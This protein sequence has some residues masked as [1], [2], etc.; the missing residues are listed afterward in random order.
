[1]RDPRHRRRSPR[2]KP[3]IKLPSFKQPNPSFA[4]PF[5][6]FSVEYPDLASK[7]GKLHADGIAA[8]NKGNLAKGKRLFNEILT[9][10]PSGNPFWLYAHNNLGACYFA[11][12][13]YERARD[14][15]LAATEHVPMYTFSLAMLTRVYLAMGDIEAAA[16]ALKRAEATCVPDNPFWVVHDDALNVMIEAYVEFGDFHSALRLVDYEEP[17]SAEALDC[18]VL[19]VAAFNL[20]RYKEANM[21][22]QLEAQ[23]DGQERMM[24][25][26]A[27]VALLLEHKQLPP[28]QIKLHEIKQEETSVEEP[29][30]YS[31]LLK[32][33]IIDTVWSDNPTAQTS[34]LTSMDKSD[35]PWVES[36][37]RAL[38]VQADLPITVKNA[39]WSALH[40]MGLVRQGEQVMMDLEGK[41][42]PYQVE[43]LEL[44]PAKRP[45]A[46]KAFLKGCQYNAKGDPKAAEAEFRKALRLYPMFPEAYLNLANA[47]RS[48]QPLDQQRFD[49]AQSLLETA[50]ALTPDYSLAW[51]NLAGLLV[52]YDK[53]HEAKTA[54]DK[55]DVNELN[56]SLVPNYWYMQGHIGVLM[57]DLESAAKAFRTGLDNA[58][59]PKVRALLQEGLD[60]INAFERAFA[61]ALDIKIDID[62]RKRMLRKS[63]RPGLPLL[64][65]YMLQT[66]EDLQN[67]A[68]A[69]GYVLPYRYTK[70]SMAEKLVTEMLEEGMTYFAELLDPKEKE[71]LYWLYKQGGSVS[72]NAFTQTYGPLSNEDELMYV[73]QL[74]PARSLVDLGWVMIGTYTSDGARQTIATLPAEVFEWIQEGGL[75]SY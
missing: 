70:A 63:I 20:Q 71:A 48:Q 10:G 28:F 23:K 19:G 27:R 24:K 52:E 35:D 44:D 45:A 73:Q 31:G 11:E 42:Q 57:G 26:L 36:F 2:R 65:A 54:L 64:E 60:N 17:V 8:M 53:V 13:Q 12:K 14:Y 38:L 30:S 1:M 41:A 34:I 4:D 39:A 59:A 22:W 43:R 25:V 67:I 58:V 33:V 18:F 37:L 66:K 40:N 46:E 51:F 16:N 21:Y 29:G 15:F 6:Y 61:R 50:V 74:Y 47:I 9:Q 72:Y 75:P 68:D 55:V 56:A 3:T 5:A 32:A 49:E 62:K 7:L 69:R